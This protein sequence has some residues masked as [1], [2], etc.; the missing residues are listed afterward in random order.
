MTNKSSTS[1]CTC[2]TKAKTFR[3]ILLNDNTL[4]VVKQQRQVF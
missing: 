4:H 3:Y 1:N 2:P